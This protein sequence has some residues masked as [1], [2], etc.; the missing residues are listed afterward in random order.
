VFTV[1]GPTGYGASSFAAVLAAAVRD[2][3]CCAGTGSAA[4]GEVTPPFPGG[5]YVSEVPHK[6]LC[7]AMGLPRTR[8]ARISL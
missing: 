2:F 5:M 4:S 1:A 6:W 7:S 3:A 8:F